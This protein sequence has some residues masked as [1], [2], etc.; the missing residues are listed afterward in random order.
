MKTKRFDC[1]LY[2]YYA[3][4]IHFVA[5]W[6]F[7]KIEID[8]EFC[9]RTEFYFPEICKNCKKGGENDEKKDTAGT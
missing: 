5:L 2:N 7:L 4:R 6:D 1:D 8:P 3:E 9:E